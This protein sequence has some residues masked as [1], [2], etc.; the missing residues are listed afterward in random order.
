MTENK[1]QH[2][3]DPC[4]DCSAANELSGWVTT[5]KKDDESLDKNTKS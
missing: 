3:D 5:P 1:E 4:D 2:N